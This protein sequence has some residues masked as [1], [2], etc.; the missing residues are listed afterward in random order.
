MVLTGKCKQD[1]EK[2]YRTTHYEDDSIVG[3]PKLMCFPTSM[4]YGVMVD[5][6][7]SI[8]IYLNISNEAYKDGVNTLWQVFE[9]DTSNEDNWSNNS[10]GLYGDNG[11]YDLDESREQ[12]IAKANQIYNNKHE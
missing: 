1:F 11:E 6:F 5:F 10:T 3:L 2:W 7:D 4:I 9:Y 8:G 12:A